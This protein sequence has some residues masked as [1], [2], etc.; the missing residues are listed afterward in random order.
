MFLEVFCNPGDFVIVFSI[1]ES[2]N[3]M[4]LIYTNVLYTIYS[5]LMY[6]TNK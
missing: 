1:S 4:D 3:E 6:N 2:Y 5:I